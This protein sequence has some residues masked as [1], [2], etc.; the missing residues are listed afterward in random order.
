MEI[1][2]HG[3]NS[4]DDDRFSIDNPRISHT[5]PTFHIETFDDHSHLVRNLSIESSSINHQNQL[6]LND[7]PQRSQSSLSCINRMLDET[8][9]NKLF[10]YNNNQQNYNTNG[11]KRSNNN[12]PTTPTSNFLSTDIFKK[13][14]VI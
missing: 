7:L 5:T 9:T 14:K 3:L 2:D 12:S 1:G 6:C 10:S 13:D 8:I 11:K 4:G